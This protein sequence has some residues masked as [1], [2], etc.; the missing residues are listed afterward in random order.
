MRTLVVSMI[1]AIAILSA[2]TVAASAVPVDGAAIARIG[3][4]VDV[5]VVVKTKKPKTKKTAAPTA[6]PPR[7]PSQSY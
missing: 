1:A 4:Q 6:P 2:G 7:E 3:Q 5:V